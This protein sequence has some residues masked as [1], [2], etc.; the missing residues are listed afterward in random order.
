M[1]DFRVALVNDDD[2]V[3]TAQSMPFGFSLHML[4]S[5]PLADQGHDLVVHLDA[6]GTSH[7]LKT[8]VTFQKRR[9]ISGASWQ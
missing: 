6:S 5:F 1:G 2:T 9:A 3:Q 4:H 8:E 7:D